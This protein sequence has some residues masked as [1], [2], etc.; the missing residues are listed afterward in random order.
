MQ[1]STVNMMK[2]D[3]FYYH[4]T[5]LGLICVYQSIMDD[6]G[7]QIHRIYVVDSYAILSWG[8]LWKLSKSRLCH[9][10]NAAWKPGGRGTNKNVSDFRHFSLKHLE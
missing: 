10:K 2:F 7:L 8:R 5:L 6:W 9:A 3:F 1:S 4:E